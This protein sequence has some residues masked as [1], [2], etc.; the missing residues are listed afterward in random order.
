[1]ATRAE[2]TVTDAQRAE[3]EKRADVARRLRDHSAEAALEAAVADRLVWLE[4]RV[5]VLTDDN[6]QMHDRADRATAVL[7]ALGRELAHARGER[8]Q[9]HATLTEARRRCA[10]VERFWAEH[11][12]EP[13]EP[14]RTYA[15]LATAL[16]S[17]RDGLAEQLTP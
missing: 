9:L 1:M 17:V 12:V 16:A 14:M 7:L 11:F 15:N 8:E 6:A 13:Q 10:L 4:E 5:A 3:Y 2:S